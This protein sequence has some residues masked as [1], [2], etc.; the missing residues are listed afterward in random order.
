MP[1][2]VKFEVCRAGVVL[3]LRLRSPSI[4]WHRPVLP[5]EEALLGVSLACF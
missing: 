4:H 2:E 1:A 5:L 3:V